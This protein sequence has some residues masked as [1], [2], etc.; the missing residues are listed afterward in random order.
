MGPNAIEKWPIRRRLYLMRHGSVEYFDADGRPFRPDT[1]PLNAEGRRQAEAA[2][3]EL[4]GVP[5]DRAVCSGLPRSAQT[6]ALVAG[7]RGLTIE[8]RSDLREIEPGRLDR[9]TL[10]SLTAADVERYFLGSLSSV[11]TPE[12]RFLNGETFASLAARVIPCFETLLSERN[13][14]RLLIVAHSV[15]NRLLLCRMLGAGLAGIGA[16][17]QDACCVN[18]VDLLEDGAALVRLVN[19]T[20][21]TPVKNGLEHTTLEELYQQF[22][23]GR[24]P[25]SSLASGGREPPENAGRSED[26][27]D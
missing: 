9:E 16:L 19:H 14:R 3:Q 6:A 26:S 15:V 4:A 22:L 11:I 24:R 13:W 1:V 27:G 18:I 8:I 2:A 23:R 20:P 7:G 10:A 12:S 21:W 5:L 17:E 25:S